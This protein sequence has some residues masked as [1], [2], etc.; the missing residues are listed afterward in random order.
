MIGNVLAGLIG[1]PFLFPLPAGSPAEWA[2]LAY[3]GVIQIA[4]AYVLLT[5]AVGRLPA[6]DVSLLLLLEPVLNPIWAWALYR[7]D[8]G[9]WA[10]FGGAVIVA[11]TAIKTAVDAR[12]PSVE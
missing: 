3:L 5:S 8:P 9:Q 7:E 11:A 6:L 4:L 2:T 12:G 10:I 1:A